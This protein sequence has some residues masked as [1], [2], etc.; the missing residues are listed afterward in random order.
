MLKEKNDKLMKMKVKKITAPGML[1]FW[2]VYFFLIVLI[3]LPS[4]NGASNQTAISGIPKI[5]IAAPTGNVPAGNIDVV[6]NVSN[7]TLLDKEK[8]KNKL[9]EG[10]IIYYLDVPVPT[11]YDHP[12]ITLSGTYQADF[13]TSYTWQNISPGIHTISVQLVNNDNKPLPSPAVDSI[14]VTVEAPKGNPSII[15]QTPKDGTDL[16]PGV[17]I[18]AVKVSNFIINKE[19]MGSV[20]RDGEG[21]LIYYIDEDPP[22]DQG[23]LATTKTSIASA[24]LSYLWKTVTEGQHTFSVQLVNNDDTPLKIPVITK[25]NINVKP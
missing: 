8:N 7:F 24:D 25:V 5:T 11:Y 10:H 1:K 4:C 9:G 19:D 22:K 17:I 16:P 6:V 20:S 3:I 15:I 12:A 13:K 14:K 23:K 2:P 21:H 18:I